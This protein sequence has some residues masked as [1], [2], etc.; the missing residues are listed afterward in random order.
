MHGAHARPNLRVEIQLDL[1]GDVLWTP[2]QSPFIDDDNDNLSDIFYDAPNRLEGS[3]SSPTATPTATLSSISMLIDPIQPR[4]LSTQPRDLS[5]P[6]RD[7]S[8]QPRDLSIPPRDLSRSPD[9]FTST[10]PQAVPQSMRL[11]AL[12]SAAAAHADSPTSVGSFRSLASSASHHTSP[13]ICSLRSLDA[14]ALQDMSEYEL[15]LMFPEQCNAYGS[16]SSQASDDFFELPDADFMMTPNVEGLRPPALLIHQLETPPTHRESVPAS[17]SYHLATFDADLD[18]AQSVGSSTKTSTSPATSTYTQATL[19]NESSAIRGLHE[20]Y[21]SALDVHQS[22]M[23]PSAVSVKKPKMKPLS[24]IPPHQSQSHPQSLQEASSSPKS[25]SA[26]N[27]FAHVGANRGSVGSNSSFPPQCFTKDNH[28]STDGEEGVVQ[29]YTIAQ[30]SIFDGTHSE[31]P[32]LPPT[33]EARILSLMRQPPSSLKKSSSLIL[34][35]SSL[36]SLNETAGS[37]DSHQRVQTPLERANN[38]NSPNF[39][40]LGIMSFKERVAG[41]TSYFRTDAPSR[42]NSFSIRANAMESDAPTH[43]RPI[44]LFGSARLFQLDQEND[45]N[46]RPPKIETLNKLENTRSLEN[47]R[48]LPGNY[49]IYFCGC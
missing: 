48:T 18:L 24:L 25:Y 26:P 36:T 49:S 43:H 23:L 3:V 5:I 8:T 38:R 42:Q 14:T 13:S 32:Q 2:P 16:D 4:D 12:Q 27:L 47:L 35:S 11:S 44:S 22:E 34:K 30:E 33:P 31:T 9:L 40:S 6:P 29:E 28:G 19:T 15:R 46:R 37:S 45:A 7:L 21:H 39:I 10:P 17:R 1:T 41:D 20:T